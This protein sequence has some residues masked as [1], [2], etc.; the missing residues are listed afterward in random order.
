MTTKERKS[1]KKHQPAKSDKTQNAT[2]N[3]QYLSQSQSALSKMGRKTKFID[4][5]NSQ[6]FHLLHRSQT[7]AAYANEQVPSDFVLVAADEVQ[8]VELSIF[9]IILICICS[10]QTVTTEEEVHVEMTLYPRSYPQTKI[11][12]MKWV[13]SMMDMIIRNT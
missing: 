11:I 7:D 5:D 4:K 13:S 8:H 6:K 3:K 1:W 12:L 10:Q 2:S 9:V